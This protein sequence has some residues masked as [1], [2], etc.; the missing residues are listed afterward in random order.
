MA[1]TVLFSKIVG[2]LL[3]VRVLSVLIDRRHFSEMVDGLEKEIRT[4]SFSLFVVGLFMTAVAILVTHSDT[5]SLAVIM[6]H[7]I[8]WGG[9][10]KGTLLILFP[11]VAVQKAKLLVQAGFLYVVLVV[12]FASGGIFT[13]FGYVAATGS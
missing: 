8:A 9:L 12:C 11:R 4:V 3:L 2:P 6:I 10:A 13:Y 5:S 7:I 1:F